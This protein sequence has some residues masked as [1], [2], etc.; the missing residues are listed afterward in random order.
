MRS[1]RFRRSIAPSSMWPQASPLAEST[2]LKNSRSPRSVLS[3]RNF[4]N[5]SRGSGYSN[6]AAVQNR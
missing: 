5:G 1:E 3:R 6:T 2:A 4:S